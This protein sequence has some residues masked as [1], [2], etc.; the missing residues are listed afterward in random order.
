MGVSIQVESELGKGS[1]FRFEFPRKEVMGTVIVP[2]TEITHPILRKRLPDLANN[3]PPESGCILIVEDN[4]TLGAYLQSI[5]AAGYNVTLTQNGAEGPWRYYP[6]CRHARP[7]KKT[8]GWS[9]Q[10]S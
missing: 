7:G 4:N 1:T 6:N 3:T 10:I 9:F 5:L 2:E 8:E